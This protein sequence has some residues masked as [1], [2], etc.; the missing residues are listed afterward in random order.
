MIYLTFKFSSLD[1]VLVEEVG[2]GGVGEVLTQMGLCSGHLVG[3]RTRMLIELLQDV[4]KLYPVLLLLFVLLDE[5]VVLEEL[6]LSLS[7]VQ[8]YWIG[9]ISGSHELFRFVIVGVYVTWF[10]K[11]FMF[12]LLEVPTLESMRAHHN[13]F[14]SE[15]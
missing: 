3:L 10:P 8:I 13:L 9:R 5:A 12:E 1:L 2:V 4:E 15:S 7:L 6:L 14:V 11:G